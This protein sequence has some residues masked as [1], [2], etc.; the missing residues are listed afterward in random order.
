M[1]TPKVV[2]L[3]AEVRDLGTHN[4]KVLRAAK[5]IPA[6]IYGP[7]VS[8][9][10]HISIAELDLER[11]L[12]SRN[13]QYVRIHLNGET[14][15]TVIKSGEFHP[16]TDRPLHVDFY[17]FA[18]AVPFTVSVPIRQQGKAAGAAVGGKVAQSLKNLKVRATADKLPAEVFVD[19][20]ALNIGD[21][22]KVKDVKW[23]DFDVVT[24]PQRLLITVNAGRK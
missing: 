11:L 13:L 23:G 1:S 24:D 2:D 12:R 16:V 20:T 10:I 5:R 6:V 3:K 17:K 7:E 21:S 15:D 4:A 9:N 8:E 22:M 14:H 18:A 19:V